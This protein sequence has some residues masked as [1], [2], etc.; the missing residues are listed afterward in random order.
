MLNVVGKIYGKYI[1]I[2]VDRVRRVT[3]LLTDYEQ[4]G[5]RASRSDLYHKADK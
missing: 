5:L 1:W 4:E 3:D 2:L